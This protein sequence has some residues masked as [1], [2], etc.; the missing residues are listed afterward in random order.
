VSLRTRLDRLE[1]GRDPGLGGW[2]ANEEHAARR[3][4]L[5]EALFEE[6]RGLCS[7][8]DAGEKLLVGA[9]PFE[10]LFD[11]IETWRESHNLG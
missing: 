5:F 3:E 10:A 1:R 11:A 6:L 9:D 2:R 8:D 4:A 7:E